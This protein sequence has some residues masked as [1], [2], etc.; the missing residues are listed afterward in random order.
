MRATGLPFFVTT[1]LSPFSA[2]AMSSEN[3]VLAS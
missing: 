2:R 3:L 1:K